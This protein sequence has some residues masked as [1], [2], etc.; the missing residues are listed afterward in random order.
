MLDMTCMYSEFVIEHRI[1]FQYLKQIL[2]LCGVPVVHAGRRDEIPAL[3]RS[4]VRVQILATLFAAD[5]A[6]YIY[7]VEQINLLSKK[8]L[9]VGS[10][11]TVIDSAAR[12]KSASTPASIAASESADLEQCVEASAAA[13]TKTVDRTVSNSP[14]ED[15]DVQADQA[16]D[17]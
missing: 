15:R 8:R 2:E 7:G 4:D 13:S 12:Q 14:A 9:H 3:F 1:L 5:S 10:D 11:Q 6:E 16:W 17:V